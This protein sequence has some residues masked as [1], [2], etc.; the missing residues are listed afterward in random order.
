MYQRH[1]QTLSGNHAKYSAVL[2]MD[3]GELHEYVL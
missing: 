3:K 2:T 1:S